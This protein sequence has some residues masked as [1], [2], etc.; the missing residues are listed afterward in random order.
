MTNKG[1]IW[2]KCKWPDLVDPKSH[3]YRVKLKWTKW[4][5]FPIFCHFA[6]NFLVFC[7]KS[8]LKSALFDKTKFTIVY[9]PFFPSKLTK[10]GKFWPLFPFYPIL[11]AFLGQFFYILGRFAKMPLPKSSK[12]VDFKWRIRAKKL[13][14]VLKWPDLVEPSV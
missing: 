9:R 5:K 2:K 8:Y 1:K 6:S 10:N 4:P 13:K 12:K 3:Q 7:P 14:K 11:M